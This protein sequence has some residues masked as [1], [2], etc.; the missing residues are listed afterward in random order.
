MQHSILQQ[1][2]SLD[3]DSLSILLSLYPDDLEGALTLIDTHQIVFCSIQGFAPK[4]FTTPDFRFFITMNG[5]SCYPFINK[6][7][8]NEEK[9]CKHIL[10]ATLITQ[11][12]LECTKIEQKTQYDEVL[13]LVC[14]KLN[15]QTPEIEF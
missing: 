1:I 11:C 14:S 6:T 15:K 5:C 2:T 10:A 12:G 8:R 3:S 9:M 7:R 4:F 13:K